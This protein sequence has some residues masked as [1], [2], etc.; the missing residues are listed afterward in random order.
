MAYYP[1][2]DV[3]IQDATLICDFK[4]GDKSAFDVL[5]GKYQFRV[6][7]TINHYVHDAVES[8]DL[9]QE[10]FM[11]A[12]QS[13]AQFRG[14][15]HFYTWLYRIAVNT[16]KHYLMLKRREGW[17]NQ[18]P[19]YLPASAWQDVDVE[20]NAPENLLISR[21]TEN[22]F[23]SILEHLP[24]E[25]RTALTLRD[26]EGKSYEEIAI[27]M[28]CHIGTVR[29]RIFRARTAIDKGMDSAS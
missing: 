10:V 18:T 22:Q 28:D 9:A 3:S 7:R 14:D 17:F 5:V 23:L 20:V 2:K 4:A 13:I 8:N 16:A 24:C 25:L 6:L 11:R 19:A 21:E 12:F 26:R 1:K 29:S 15:S 27:I